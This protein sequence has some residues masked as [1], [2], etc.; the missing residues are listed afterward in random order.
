VQILA[1][2]IN[3]GA[4]LGHCELPFRC[5]AAMRGVFFVNGGVVA[6]NSQHVP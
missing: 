3:R 4:L 2:T 5:L 1:S 6:K